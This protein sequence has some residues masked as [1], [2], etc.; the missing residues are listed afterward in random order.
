MTFPLRIHGRV[1]VKNMEYLQLSLK[2]HDD[3]DKK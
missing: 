2:I 1:K 3:K